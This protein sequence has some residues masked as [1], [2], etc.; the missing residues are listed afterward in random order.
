MWKDYFGW[1]TGLSLQNAGTSADTVRVLYYDF[2]GNLLN[3][4]DYWVPS[5][6]AAAIYPLPVGNGTIGSA[7]AYSLG[8]QPISVV[9]NDVNANAGTSDAWMVTTAINR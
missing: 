7:V 1:G 8:G 4:V 2:Y 9:A 3:S 5:L 6:S